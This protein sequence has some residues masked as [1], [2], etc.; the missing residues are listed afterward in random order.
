[1]KVVNLSE[2]QFDHFAINHKYRNYYQS[3]MYGNLIKKFGYKIQYI[4]IINDNN[5]LIGAT[6]IMYKEVFMKNRIGYAPRGI[7]FNYDNIENIPEMVEVLKK[8]LSKQSYMLLRMDPY[9]P[10]SIRNYQGE[11]LNLNNKVDEIAETLVSQGFEYKGKTVNFEGEKPRWESIVL[12]NNDIRILFE[13]FD[14]RTRNK[15]RRASSLGIEVKKDETKN[16]K[17]LYNFIRTKDNK[18][19][20]YYEELLKTFGNDT[21]IYYATINTETFIINARRTYEKEMEQNNNL[22]EIIQDPTIGEKTRNDY[23]NRKMESD[24]L[25]QI[26][27]NNMILSTKLLK[28]YPNGIPIAGALI[29]KYDNAAYEFIEGVDDRYKQLNASYLLKWKLI[30]DYNYQKL[31]YLNLNGVVG[32]FQNK[33]KFSGLNEM[34]LGFNSTVIEY[35]GEFD[36]TINKFTLNLYKNLNKK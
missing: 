25:L 3:S 28:Q 14:K 36:L 15:I 34:K 21:E 23:L 22:Q 6:L 16:L 26:Y 9:I 33:S 27:K 20:A 35:I 31:K 17:Y 1:M 10:A 8:S 29:I 2:S 12:L 24:S 30:E 32:D 18:P 7:L 11:I 13:S 19:L 4:G 5:K